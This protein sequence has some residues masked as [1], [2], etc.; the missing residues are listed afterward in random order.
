[1]IWKILKYNIIEGNS[2]W[3]EFSFIY[4][5][6]DL[7]MHSDTYPNIILFCSPRVAVFCKAFVIS[8][9]MLHFTRVKNG[10]NAFHAEV[11]FQT[12]SP[13]K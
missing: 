10:F 7:I 4:I 13:A 1:M 3:A 5:G 8:Q 11:F 9:N 6:N 2:I 12:I